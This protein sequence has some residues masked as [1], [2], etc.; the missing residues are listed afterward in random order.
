MEHSIGTDA[1]NIDGR[2]LDILPGDAVFAQAGKRPYLNLT[3]KIERLQ[4]IHTKNT[5]GRLRAR[6][7]DHYSH[8]KGFVGRNICYAIVFDGVYYGHT[9]GGS[10]TRFLKGRNEFLE[11]SLDNLNCVV[12]NVFYNVSK[13]DGR[14]PIRNFVPFVIRRF[15]ST[16]SIDWY[17]KYGDSVLGFETLIEKPRSGECY[18][19]AGWSLVG[20]T[21]GYTCKRI[22]GKGTDSWSGKRVWN[23]DKNSLRPK[24]CFCFKM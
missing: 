6:M 21:K 4:L 22:A 16:I 7:R 23:T 24:W 2:Q 18:R 15:V 10:A 12:N 19:R 20:E 3:P 5:D 17:E 11:I 14:Y 8:P 1:Y 9:V 13:V